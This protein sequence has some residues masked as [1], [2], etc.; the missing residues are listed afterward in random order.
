MPY[1]IGQ[2]ATAPVNGS[3]GSYGGTTTSGGSTSG[4]TTVNGSALNEVINFTSLSTLNIAWNATRKAAF[5][6]A[7]VINVYTISDD[8]KYRLTAVEVIPDSI[9]APTNYQINFGDF[10]S[11]IVIIS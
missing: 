6:D 1:L 11:G 10:M 4:G 2:C 9:T 3:G 5:G 7:P 8:G